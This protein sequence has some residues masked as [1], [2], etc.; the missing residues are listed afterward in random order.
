MVSKHKARKRDPTQLRVERNPDEDDEAAMA[1]T[2]IRPTVQAGVTIL[3]YGKHSVGGLDLTQLVGS[4]SDQ[5]KAVIGGD[6]T[7]AETM[8]TAQAHALDTIFNKL[9]QISAA[10]LPGH[11]EEFETFMKLALRAQAQC[12]ATWE[13]LATIKNPPLVGY[14][15]QTNIAHGPQQVIN[16]PNTHARE[17]QN[18]PNKLLEDTEHEPDQWLDQGAPRT[19]AGAHLHVET[20][21]KIDGAK[22]TAG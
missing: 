12:R 7:R 19:A 9:A 5:T 2:F 3:E 20:M 22:N 15:R 14:A 13:T 10:N 16:E 11:L 21:G 18:P 4:L 6:L 1:R 8:L 17:N